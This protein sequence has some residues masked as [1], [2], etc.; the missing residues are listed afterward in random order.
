MSSRKPTAPQDAAEVEAPFRRVA[1]PEAALAAPTPADP[2]PDITLRSL[3]QAAPVGIGLV[4][5]QAIVWANNRL[6]DMLGYSR[7]DLAGM[8]V[9]GLYPSGE[10]YER[11]GR[12]N[13]AALRDQGAGSVETHWV[14][15]DKTVLDVLLSAAA[16]DPDDLSRGLALTVQDITTR[17][18]AEE[19]LREGAA[20]FRE[21]AGNLDLVFYSTTRTGLVLYANPAYETMFGRSLGA[22]ARNHEDWLAAVH[23][24]DLPGLRLDLARQAQDAWFGVKEY[25]VVLPGGRVRWVRDRAVPVRDA[26]GK[27]LRVVGFVEDITQRVAVEQELRLAK[28]AAEAANRAKNEFL[29]AASHDLRT[30]LAGILGMLDLSLDESLPGRVRICLENAKTASR[31]LK[32][33]LDDLLDLARMEARKLVLAEEEFAPGAVL[34]AAAEAFR[35][36]AEARGLTLRTRDH[37]A[38]RSLLGDPVRVRQVLANLIGNAV[39]FTEKGRVEVRLW[40]MDHPCNGPATLFMEVSDTGMGIPADMRESIFEPF[41]QLGDPALAARRGSGL[42][43][44]IVRRIVEHMDGALEIESREGRGTCVRVAV[45]LRPASAEGAGP[46]PWT[47][48]AGPEISLSVLL[49]EDNPVNRLAAQMMLERAGHRVVAV[50]DGRAALQNALARDFDCALMDI[51]MPELDGLSAMRL[52][53]EAEAREG[54]PRL[55]VVAMTAYAMKGDRE[56]FLEAGFDGYLSKPVDTGELAAALAAATR[57]RTRSS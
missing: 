44:A 4:R 42:G 47:A 32:N 54:R 36:Q 22:L 24:A 55:P 3:L 52:L 12:V 37:T 9:R 56:R 43:L 23:P 30:P 16:L 45:R 8:P 35:A 41:T 15:K 1:E 21:L 33:L 6:V 51:S 2:I 25:R 40:I 11:V 57:D 27:L 14:R 5:E 38:G 48:P 18:R 19:A 26:Q 50:E 7:E 49:A 13:H 34:H 46:G 20:R 39:K 10:E 31:D 28:E 53:R 29:A 17:K